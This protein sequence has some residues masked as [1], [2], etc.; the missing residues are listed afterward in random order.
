MSDGVYDPSVG[1]GRETGADLGDAFS[2][3]ADVG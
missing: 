3:D 1:P 2:H